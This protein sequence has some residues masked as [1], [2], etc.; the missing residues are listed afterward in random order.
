M[1]E[2]I[3]LMHRNKLG[4]LALVELNDQQVSFITWHCMR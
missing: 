2:E 1:S 4:S 3:L